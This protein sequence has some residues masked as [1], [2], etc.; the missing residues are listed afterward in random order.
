MTTSTIL[1]NI[2][3]QRNVD[4]EGIG[5]QRAGEPGGRGAG[6]PGGRGAGGRGAMLKGPRGEL[7]RLFN[8]PNDTNTWQRSSHVH[9]A[10][11]Q[12]MHVCAQ[13]ER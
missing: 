7:C 5:G 2:P 12:R 10:N 8:L 13:L 3:H 6:G 11:G 1:V 9:A 4:I